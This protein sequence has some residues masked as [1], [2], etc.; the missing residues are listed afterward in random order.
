MAPSAVAKVLDV[1]HD[2]G[3]V[4]RAGDPEHVYAGGV[5]FWVRPRSEPPES[6]RARKITQELVGD[7]EMLTAYIDMNR[8]QVVAPLPLASVLS[9]IV[10]KRFDATF[11]GSPG[12]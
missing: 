11:T 2:R 4:E 7:D 12:V 9:S 8:R 10:D 1:L 5:E 6:G 3:V